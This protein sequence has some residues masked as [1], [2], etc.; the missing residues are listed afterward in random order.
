MPE[1]YE[2]EAVEPFIGGSEVLIIKDVEPWFTGVHGPAIEAVLEELNKTY[3][4]INSVQLNATDL[5]A[6]DIVIV[7]IAS[8]QYTS[9]YNRLIT[10]KTKLSDYVYGGGVLIAHACD[11]GW[12]SYPGWTTSWL[13]LGVTKVN[14]Y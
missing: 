2:P 10:E 5:T 6:Y 8:D 11:H 4:V 7:I 13:P 9:T 14:T 3:D 12:H 1:G